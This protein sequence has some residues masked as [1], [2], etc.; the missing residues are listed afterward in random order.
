MSEQNVI[1]TFRILTAAAVAMAA[2]LAL[3][4]PV[5]HD[6]L[7]CLYVARRMLAGA[8][9][10]GPEIFESNPPLIMWASYLLAIL[11]RL[12][13][14]PI[15]ILFKLA[16]AAI[17]VAIGVA[18]LRI[19]RRVH[20]GLTGGAGWMLGF[21]FAVIYAVAPARDYGQRDHL[22]ALL[23]LPYVLGAAVDSLGGQIAGTARLTLPARLLLGLA[24]AVGL[25]LKPHNAL[26]VLTTEFLLFLYALSA[27][28]RSHPLPRMPFRLRTELLTIVAG[29]GLYLGAVH[30]F[31]PAYYTQVIPVLKDTYWAI[32]H[33]SPA[34]LLLQAIQLH[35]LLLITITVYFVRG[36][37]KS[38]PV[39]AFLLAAGL[40]S[41]VAYYLQGTG[42]YYQQLPAISFTAAALAVLGC[43]MFTEAKPRLSWG[44]SLPDWTPAAALLLSVL[45]L[46]L[47]AHFTDYPFVPS[48]SFPIDVPD[49]SFF[50]SLPPGTPVAILTTSVDAT[51]MPVAKYHLVWAQRTNNL[52]ILPAILRNESGP[53]PQ[54]VIPAPRLAELDQM[55]HRFMVEDLDRW[56]PRLILVDRCQDPRVQC[57]VLEDRHDNLLAWFASDPAFRAAFAPYRYSKSVGDYD[58]YTLA[59]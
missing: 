21:A 19:L 31:T 30:R 6:Q 35:V 14:I 45:A 8:R 48:H 57:Q 52:W 3:F 46:A 9:L 44:F 32:G 15:T 51:V 28:R 43:P 55:Q 10:Y 12:T 42:W 11:S 41:T 24:G 47:T 7:W 37:R 49:E 4:P 29:G 56:H 23:C 50:W 36:I 13:H 38:G 59:P 33:L 27:S 1:R 26:L 54:H 22:L 25:C 20:P 58:A 2:L 18:S 40:A 16:V 39:P 53:I 34:E 17:E 5:G